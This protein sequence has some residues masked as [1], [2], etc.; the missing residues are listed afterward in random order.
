MI[1][2]KRF[3]FREPKIRELRQHLSFARNSVRH[4]YV[5]S[6]DAVRRYKEQAVPQIKNFPDLP[7]LQFFDARELQLQ[8]RVAWHGGNMK[9]E[10]CGASEN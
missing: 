3:R 9:G 7:A 10:V 6:R 2:L 5:E 1:R 8:Q 4:H